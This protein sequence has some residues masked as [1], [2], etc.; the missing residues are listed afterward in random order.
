MI[1][2]NMI[3]EVQKA[4]D[5]A[6]EPLRTKL[7]EI[8]AQITSKQAELDEL[9]NTRKFI[10]ISLNRI[11]GEPKTKT[12]NLSHTTPRE[13][14]E[15]KIDYIETLIQNNADSLS[16]GFTSVTI[17]ELV[18]KDMLERE[19]DSGGPGIEVIRRALD[20][21]HRRAVIRLDRTGRGG[22]R[23]YKLVGSAS[24]AA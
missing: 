7:A 18:K 14:D 10:Q 9:W 17:K 19:T 2:E 1:N 23:I 16:D 21:L 8:A 5:N 15:P 12:K 11:V 4:L 13:S 6:A 3:D 20:A 24:H 22:S